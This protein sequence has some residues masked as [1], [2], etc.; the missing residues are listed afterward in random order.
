MQ[1]SE[2]EDGE[3]VQGIDS[4][5]LEYNNSINEINMDVDRMLN[6]DCNEEKAEPSKS[7]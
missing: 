2:G 5:E 6:G 3:F 7:Q 4:D 1:S